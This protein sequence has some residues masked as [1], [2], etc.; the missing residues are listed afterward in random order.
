VSKLSAFLALVL[1]EIGL[2]A[3]AATLV[4]ERK[5][6]PLTADK[7]VVIEREASPPG[8]A[9][10]TPRVDIATLAWEAAGQSS[11]TAFGGLAPV[12]APAPAGAG[13]MLARKLA[14]LG[15]SLQKREALLGPGGALSAAKIGGK[16]REELGIVVTGVNDQPEIVQFPGEDAAGPSG[17]AASIPL[18]PAA[19]ADLR[20]HEARWGDTPAGDLLVAGDTPSPTPARPRAFDASEG[21]RLDPLRNKTYGLSYAK[22]I[23]DDIK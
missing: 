3:F 15:A 23:P 16:S 22:V 1:I 20:A 9:S 18:P 10:P 12:A 21:T 6:P 11:L 13:A 5:A 19:L 7:I 4:E 14:K 17:P 2:V 8:F